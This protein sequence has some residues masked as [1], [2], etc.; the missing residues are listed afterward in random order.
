MFLVMLDYFYLLK[1]SI[2]ILSYLLIR[3]FDHTE[4]RAIVSPFFRPPPGQGYEKINA[5]KGNIIICIPKLSLRQTFLPKPICTELLQLKN[6][7]TVM[8][9]AGFKIGRYIFVQWSPVNTVTDWSCKFDHINEIGS[10]FMTGL[11]RVTSHIYISLQY[12]KH[13][14]CTY[15]FEKNWSFNQCIQY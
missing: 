6:D 14:E 2:V 8:N 9:Q 15:Y 5:I 10:Y 1:W 12:N 7:G 4:S 11:N 3:I 13:P